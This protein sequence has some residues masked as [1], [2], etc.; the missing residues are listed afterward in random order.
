MLLCA[1]RTHIEALI[2][3]I[4]AIGNGDNWLRCTKTVVSYRWCGKGD[5][6]PV[7]EVVGLGVG[8]LECAVVEG[9]GESLG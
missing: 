5:F 8:A 6:A 1:L 9:C 4:N 3:I 2:R 7:A